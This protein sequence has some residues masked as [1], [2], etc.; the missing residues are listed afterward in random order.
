MADHSECELVL[1]ALVTEKLAAANM[2]WQLTGESK[3]LF[4]PDT[5]PPPSIT[6]P[7]LGFIRCVS[8][9]YIVCH[10]RG[11]AGTRFLLDWRRDDSSALAASRHFAIIHDLRTSLHH[12]LNL[13]DNRDLAL[14]RRCGDWSRDVCGSA[15]PESDD[16]WFL[17]LKALLQNTRETLL[18]YLIST[19]RA[20]DE[21]ESRNEICRVWCKRVLSSYDPSDFDPIVIDVLH[22]FGQGSID[23]VRVRKRFY[24][25]WKS[26]LDSL[27]PGFDFA[28]EARRLIEGSI[29]DDAMPLLPITGTDVRREFG[30]VP[31]TTVREYMSKARQLYL[32]TPAIRS[33]ELIEALRTWS[34][35][36]DTAQCVTQSPEQALIVNTQRSP[37]SGS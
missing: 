23:A 12:F 32:Q 5:L 36:G 24:Q 8:W 1:G 21:D 22:D 15:F 4:P 20:I 3:A 13:E 17:C 35:A 26:K 2:A 10:E 11:R 37:G 6:V 14:A 19:I 16:Q 30:L 33:E 9:L 34:S 28:S 29:L 27:L 7:E 25:Q 18:N 31:G